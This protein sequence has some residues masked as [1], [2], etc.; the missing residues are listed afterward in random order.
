M[1]HDD[2]MKLLKDHPHKEEILLTLGTPVEPWETEDYRS[3]YFVKAPYSMDD[4]SPCEG[5]STVH[6]LPHWKGGFKSDLYAE[7]V[8]RQGA[9]RALHGLEFMEK[10]NRNGRYEKAGPSNKAKVSAAYLKQH[11]EE[12]A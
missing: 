2:L 5:Q 10:P 7:H 12:W 4:A 6:R 1:K 8:K 3:G 9:K 11:R